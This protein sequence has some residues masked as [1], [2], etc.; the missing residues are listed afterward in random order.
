MTI[1]GA[2]NEILSHKNKETGGWDFMCGE[3]PDDCKNCEL[4]EALDIAI[5]VLNEL[6]K[7]IEKASEELCDQVEK[8]MLEDLG[9]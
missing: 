8:K 2:R 5:A 6:N 7:H 3:C 4:S 1:E 9:L